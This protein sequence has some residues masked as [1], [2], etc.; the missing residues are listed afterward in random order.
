[1]LR[2]LVQLVNVIGEGGRQVRDLAVFCLGLLS[3]QHEATVRERVD[4][5]RLQYRCVSCWKVV[6][7]SGEIW[8]PSPKFNQPKVREREIVAIQ[9]D[10][11]GRRVRLVRKERT[12]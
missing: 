11:E 3:C 7:R 4:Q 6:L 2:F 8:V 12:G 10:R 1:M 5:H 9:A